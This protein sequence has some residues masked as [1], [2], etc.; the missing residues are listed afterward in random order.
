M[1]LKYAK[2]GD[3]L[4]KTAP[5]VGDSKELQQPGPQSAAEGVHFLFTD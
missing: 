5:H 4:K 2:K 1:E 3:L